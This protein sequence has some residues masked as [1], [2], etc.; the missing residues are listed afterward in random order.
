MN[1]YSTSSC[2]HPLGESRYNTHQSDVNARVNLVIEREV[3][4]IHVSSYSTPHCISLHDY[5]YSL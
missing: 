3:L 2:L 1:S 4:T 5:N